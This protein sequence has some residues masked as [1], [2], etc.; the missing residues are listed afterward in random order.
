MRRFKLTARYRQWVGKPD[1]AGHGVYTISTDDPSYLHEA[2]L[3]A[4][5]HGDRVIKIE[6]LI[7]GTYR[8]I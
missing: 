6:K 2:A 4:T 3:N 8:R 5:R 7:N 1:P